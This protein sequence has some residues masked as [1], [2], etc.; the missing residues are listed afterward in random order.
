VVG[1]RHQSDMPGFEGV[2][3]ADQ[4]RAVLAFIKSTW[5]ERE[6]QY[7]LEMSRRDA[8]EPRSRSELGEANDK[9]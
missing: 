5:P 9:P 4:I 7:Q 6:R 2:L 8:A 3:D 1:Q